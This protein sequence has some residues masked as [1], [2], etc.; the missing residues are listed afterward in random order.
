MLFMDRCIFCCWRVYASDAAFSNPGSFGVMSDFYFVMY[1]YSSCC[2]VLSILI[3][4]I[5]RCP[6]GPR[7]LLPSV[8]KAPVAFLC[9]YLMDV[10]LSRILLFLPLLRNLGMVLGLFFPSMFLVLPRVVLCNLRLEGSVW[11]PYLSLGL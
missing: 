5:F 7:V 9:G 10:S 1:F 3:L 6:S 4:L 8:S 11:G 2:C